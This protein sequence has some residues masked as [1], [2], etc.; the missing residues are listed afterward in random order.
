MKNH[1]LENNT[2][3]LRYSRH[4]NLNEIGDA[5][6]E[7]IFSA[8]ILIIGLGG[9]GSPI[10]LYLAAAGVGELGLMDDDVV[11]ISNLQRQIIYSNNDL[12]KSK[13]EIT[14]QQLQQKAS[15]I[16]TNCYK[17]RFESANAHLVADYDFVIDASDNFQ[18]KFLIND[19]CVKHKTAYSHAGISAFTGQTMTIIPKKSACFRCVFTAPPAETIQ[20]PTGPLGVLPGVI[21]TI[22]ATEALKYILGIGSLLTNRI[23]I[24]DAL[25]MKFREVTIKPSSHCIACND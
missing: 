14:A 19:S 15:Y 11:E 18:T 24:F 5:G 1:R 25:Q 6:Q 12:G 10:A 16:K 9:L 7:R 20:P 3:R 2:E 13:V 17:Q 4:L 21:G 8:R 23:L 22:Q